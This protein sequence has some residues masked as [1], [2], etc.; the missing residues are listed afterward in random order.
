MHT[1]NYAAFRLR[2]SLVSLCKHFKPRSL[3]CLGKVAGVKARF[4]RAD[5]PSDIQ[6]TQTKKARKRKTIKPAAVE[7]AN[8]DLEETAELVQQLE[9]LGL[10]SAFGTSKASHIP[11]QL[12][13]CL[14]CASSCSF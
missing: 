5:Y 9:E 13:R 14:H 3:K 4:C 12:S 8:S 6:R 1:D 11:M 2:L 7:P 10:P